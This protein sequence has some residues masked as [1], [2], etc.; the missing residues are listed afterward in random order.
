MGDFKVNGVTPTYIYT[1]GMAVSKIYNG[2]ELVWPKDQVGEITICNQI[3]KNENSIE[4]RQTSS[5]DLI[6]FAGNFQEW[7]NF[8]NANS[9]CVAW[10]EFDNNNSA[11]GLYYNEFALLTV[12][13]PEGFRIPTRPD[14]TALEQ[15]VRVPNFNYNATG[16]NSAAWDWNIDN[17]V[18]LNSS[19]FNML[20]V[21]RIS[22]FAS[23][24]FT[25][26]GSFGLIWTKSIASYGDQIV[27]VAGGFSNLLST[28][29]GSEG[30]APIRF[31]KDV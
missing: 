13:V 31:V 12:R 3:W 18:G 25:G 14:W 11:Y 16:T 22:R 30:G 27:G 28:V 23:G 10:Y 7:T 20:P 29:S 24:G 2:S 5:E 9:P 15:C 26:F 1:N 19:G 8:S 6:P 4:T 17:E 21:G